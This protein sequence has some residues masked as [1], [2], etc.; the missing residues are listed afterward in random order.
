MCRLSWTECQIGQLR[1]STQSVKKCPRQKPRTYP[2]YLTKQAPCPSIC[3]P[4][5]AC[6]SSSWLTH[7]PQWQ[8]DAGVQNHV[9]WGCRSE[10]S[11]PW[12]RLSCSSSGHPRSLPRLQSPWQSG[13]WIA[14]LEASSLHLNTQSLRGWVKNTWIPVLSL[15]LHFLINY[16]ILV[17]SW[18]FRT[19]FLDGFSWA[20]AHLSP[21]W[22]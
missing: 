2:T 17:S 22:P 1:W 21:C 6:S 5:I 15:F 8:G 18:V 14:Y 19:L 16:V 3:H 7:C 4:P 9:G 11:S 12:G 10:M 13:S 20:D